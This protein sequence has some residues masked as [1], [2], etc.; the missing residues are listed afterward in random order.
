MFYAGSDDKTMIKPSNCRNF[1]K[2]GSWDYC[3][4]GYICGFQERYENSCGWCD[5]TALN[6]VQFKCCGFTDA[7]TPG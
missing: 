2:W 7:P 5:D 1:G 3:T 6:A 4:N